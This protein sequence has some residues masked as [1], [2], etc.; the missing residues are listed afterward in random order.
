MEIYDELREHADSLQGTPYTRGLAKRAADRIEELEP[1]EHLVKAL[2]RHN[3]DM[4]LTL[5]QFVE[6][7][8]SM[9][10]Q[11]KKGEL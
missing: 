3:A 5:E 6:R 4:L 11:H 10:A 1:A 9:L 7:M 2:K 8:K